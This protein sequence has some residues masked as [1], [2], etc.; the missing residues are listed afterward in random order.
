MFVTIE[1]IEGSGKST[2]LAGL[3]ERLRGDRPVVVTREPGGT[4][5]G[6]AIRAIFLDRSIEIDALTEAMLVNAARAAHVAGVIRPALAEGKLVLCDRFV[7]ST[8]AYQ[9]FGRGYD[10][11]K[12]RQICQIATGGLEPGLTLLVDVSLQASRERTRARHPE[13]DRIESEDDGFHDRVRRGFLELARASNRHVVLDGSSDAA[14]LV[15]E[16]AATIFERLR[17]E[18]PA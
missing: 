7:D 12:L 10:L 15:D 16:A 13:L 2:L 8:L 3:F 5:A 11:A 17:T 6:D 18:S 4:P 1:G 14:A 9:G